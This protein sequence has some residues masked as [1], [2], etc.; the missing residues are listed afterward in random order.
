MTWHPYGRPEEFGFYYLIRVQP[1]EE[2]DS[3]QKS[4]VGK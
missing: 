3:Y 2:V 4:L 1:G